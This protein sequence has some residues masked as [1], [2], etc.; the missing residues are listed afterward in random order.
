MKNKIL[1]STIAGTTLMLFPA[2]ALSLGGGG[3]AASKPNCK[4]GYIFSSKRKKCVRK[5]PM[6]KRGYIFSRKK[7]K[8]VRKYSELFKDS[9]LKIQGW[10]LAYAG[11]YQAAIEMFNMVA[12][13]KD[14]EA[15][16]GLG[17]SHRK[18][19]QFNKGISFYKLALSINP[20]YVLA[21]EYLGEGFVASGRIDLANKQLNEIKI[22]CG[23]SCLAYIKLA[24][25]IKTGSNADW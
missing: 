11:R 17:Y 12:N 19:G 3:F 4:T 14:E 22:R 16:N 13:K 24:Q 15:L 21:R 25:V 5:P 1:L 23:T 20:N 7:R 10:T 18:S 9:D 8:C 2:Q 6:C